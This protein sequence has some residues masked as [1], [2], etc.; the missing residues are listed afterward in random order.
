[1]PL[2]SESSS[3]G[4]ALK[5][6]KSETAIACKVLEGEQTRRL[7][8]YGSQVTHD[9]NPLVLQNSGYPSIGPYS[10]NKPKPDNPSDKVHSVFPRVMRCNAT[11]I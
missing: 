5:I 6:Q 3:S 8:G 11:V 7:E 10:D 9:R 2:I 1:M 4:M